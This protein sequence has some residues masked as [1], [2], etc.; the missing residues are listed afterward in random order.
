MKKVEALFPTI[1]T[2]GRLPN[3]TALNQQLLKEIKDFSSQ[4][5]MGQE[6]SKIN[7]RGGYTS[8]ASLNDMHYRS[9]LFAKVSDLLQPHAVAFAKA[10]GWRIRGRKLEMT[11][12]WM[13][14]MP[15]HTYHNLHLHPH[16][17]ISGSY[18][19]STPKGSVSLKLEDPRMPFYMNAPTRPLY[20]EVV[21]QPGTFV[22][23]E[24]WLRHEVPPNQ[25]TQPRIGLSFNYS[26]V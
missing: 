19:V 9:P 16:S 3:A 13:N 4:D 7:Y 18:Y 2:R 20:H 23:F 26:R 21:P 14:V 12:L 10:Q 8:Y 25:S 1:I 5:R 15:R 24:S 17:V 22:M 11:D 6:W